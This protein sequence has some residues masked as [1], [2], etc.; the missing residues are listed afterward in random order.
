MAKERRR[1]VYSGRVQGVGFRFTCE[2]LASG[3]DV[4]GWVR[5]ERDGTVR[6]V[7]EGEPEVLDRFLAAIQ[8]AMDRNIHSVSVEGEDASDPLGPG[9]EI[10][11]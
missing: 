5:N 3:L 7:A 2:R 4:S 11:Y 10:R 9:F 8:T 6:L 1:V